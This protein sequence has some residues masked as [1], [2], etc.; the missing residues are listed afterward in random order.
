MQSTRRPGVA[1]TI[2]Q[3]LLH[4]G[5]WQAGAHIEGK[6]ARQLPCSR[7]CA[8]G[9]R[10]AKNV[11][12]S[13]R[14]QCATIQRRLAAGSLPAACTACTAHTARTACTACTARAVP[15]RS[16]KPWSSM[17][18]PPTTDTTRKSV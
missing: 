4:S 18:W 11:F 12:R 1:T 7:T 14:R 13:R 15:H 8:F 2:S 3:P 6:Q 17:D 16:K 5:E 9:S 10:A